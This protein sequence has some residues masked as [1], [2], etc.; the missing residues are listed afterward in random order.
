M[1]EQ[2]TFYKRALFPLIALIPLVAATIWVVT[3]E[4]TAT[5]ETAFQPQASTQPAEVSKPNTQAATTAPLQETADEVAHQTPTSLGDDP[6]APSL[7]GTDIDGS[8]KADANGNLIVRDQYSDV[9][10][11]RRYMFIEDS[12][13]ESSLDVPGAELL[14][15]GPDFQGFEGLIPI[16]G[17]N[18]PRGRGRTGGRD[19]IGG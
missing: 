15:N 9:A 13:G 1:S 17:G 19:R 18:Q 5:P 4:P 11:Y 10:D 8:L 3:E 2:S 16:E 7:A 6:F 14:E 12:E